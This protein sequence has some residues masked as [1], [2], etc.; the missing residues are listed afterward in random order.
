MASFNLDSVDGLNGATYGTAL[1]E[2]VLYADVNQ[3]QIMIKLPINVSFKT[4]AISN[5]NELIPG[6]A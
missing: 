6:L 2:S 1:V 5:P 4:K 3:T